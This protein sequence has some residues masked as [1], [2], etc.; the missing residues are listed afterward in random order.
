MQGYRNPIPAPPF[1]LAHAFQPRGTVHYPARLLLRP[2]QLHPHT[3]ITP[4]TQWPPHPNRPP[5]F[6]PTSVQQYGGSTDINIK[7]LKSDP[8]PRMETSRI[9]LLRWHHPIF[10]LLRPNHPTHH[11]SNL[12]INEEDTGARSLVPRPATEAICKPSRHPTSTHLKTNSC[13]SSV[14]SLFPLRPASALLA[15]QAVAWWST[16][17]HS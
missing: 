12:P 2:A 10:A 16:L 4:S 3:Y 1:R 7:P 15:R 13:T 5:P 8:T 6:C 17:V 14:A 11:P 9:Q